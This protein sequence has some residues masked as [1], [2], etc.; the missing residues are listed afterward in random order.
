MPNGLHDGLEYVTDLPGFNNTKP[1]YFD[2]EVIDH[3]LSIVLDLGAELSV[4]KDRMALIEEKLSK[5]EEISP[6]I[7]DFAEP[8]ESLQSRLAAERQR[9]IHRI[10]G[11]LYEK[12]GGDELGDLAAPIGEV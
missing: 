2:N 6:E 1:A 7:L 5:G 8:S 10:Y 3:L 9:T 11:C 12:Y 4:T